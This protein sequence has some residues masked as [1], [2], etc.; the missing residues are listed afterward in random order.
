[1]ESQPPGHVQMHLEVAFT[2]RCRRAD[3]EVSVEESQ[4]EF[5]FQLPR[6][7]VDSAGARHRAGKMR[8][9][10]AHDELLPL[11]DH[12]VQNNPAYLTVVLLARVITSLGNLHGDAIRPE[13]IESLYASDLAYLQ[14]LYR[15]L[16]SF[17]HSRAVVE[18][19]AC[20]ER[21]SV[22]P[23]NGSTP[24]LG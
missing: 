6:G 21:F 23:A 1:M 5:E 17:G 12:R 2:R 20:H 11:S 15:Q 24:Q 22:D 4:S 18:C 3:P 9:A 19:P 14:D 7:F 10:T 13:V 8:L 16:N